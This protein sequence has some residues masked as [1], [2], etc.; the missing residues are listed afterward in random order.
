MSDAVDPAA[1]ATNS[2]GGLGRHPAYEL[3]MLVL[4][5]GSLLILAADALLGREPEVGRL[6]Q[7]ADLAV[8]LVFMADFGRNLVVAKGRARYFFTW[9]WL[10]LLSS[11]PSVDWL[12]LARGA[13]IVRALR[14]VRALRGSRQ[15]G[16]MLLAHRARYGVAVALLLAALLVFVCSFAVLELEVGPQANIGSAADALW[17][18]V[19]TVTTV[20]YGDKVPTTLAAK[21][22]GVVLMFSGI[23]LFSVLTAGFASWFF[24]A[25]ERARQMEEIRKEL[26]ELRRAIEDGRDRGG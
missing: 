21:V 8:C 4:S 7:W 13:R 16:A 20:G 15:L 11:I 25:E 17:W 12:R 10:D 18:A 19:A 5:V 6:L 2:A 24:G 26:G 1:G 9:G 14:V 22:V 23:A 3:L